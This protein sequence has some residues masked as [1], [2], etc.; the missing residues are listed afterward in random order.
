MSVQIFSDPLAMSS[1][2]LVQ[3]YD[4]MGPQTVAREPKN[5]GQGL[6]SILSSLTE[7][8]DSGE[9]LGVVEMKA[10]PATEG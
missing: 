2:E 4:R 3:F 8:A 6:Q 10:T 7:F 9:I 5:A 1:E